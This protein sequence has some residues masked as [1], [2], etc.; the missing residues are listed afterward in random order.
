MISVAVADSICAC[1][2]DTSVL[3]L[4]TFGCSA[5]GGGRFGYA[6]LSL[7]LAGLRVRRLQPLTFIL[8]QQLG[9]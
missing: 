8:S 9:T 7:S 3:L 6:E 1:A 5:S 4:D 2:V